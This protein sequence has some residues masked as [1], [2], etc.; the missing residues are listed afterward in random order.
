MTRTLRSNCWWSL[1]ANGKNF[2]RSGRGRKRSWRCLRPRRRRGRGGFTRKKSKQGSKCNGTFKLELK[3][4]ENFLALG[5]FEVLIFGLGQH[6]GS[7]FTIEPPA[8]HGLYYIKFHLRA[9][10]LFNELGQGS[11]WVFFIY[12]VLKI[13]PGSL[14]SGSGPFQL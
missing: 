2:A 14:G 9:R 8:F 1:S 13:E 10:R 3:R 12:Y 7:H 6:L 11:F 5:S 4:A